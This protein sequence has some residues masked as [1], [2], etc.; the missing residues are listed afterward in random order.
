MAGVAALTCPLP[1]RAAS[2]ATSPSWTPSP[3]PCGSSCFLP[4]WLS[5]VSC[6]W[7][8]GE[9]TGEGVGRSRS[10][11]HQPPTPAL[12]LFCWLNTVGP[13]VPCTCPVS[14]SHLPPWGSNWASLLPSLCFCL[15]TSTAECI[16]VVCQHLCS[17]HPLPLPFSSQ[18]LY[19]LLQP[20]LSLIHPLV[21]PQ[22]EPL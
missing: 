21:S 6:F 2:L 18:K 3:L 14:V 22:A 12:S 17:L 10:P 5:A 9:W 15:L 20:L 4:T 13:Q 8:P 16:P 19:Y 7:L 1:P 11:A